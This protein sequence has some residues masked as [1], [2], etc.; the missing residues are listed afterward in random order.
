MTKKWARAALSHPAFTGLSRQHLSGLIEELA[1]PWCA[2][3]EAALHERRGHERLRAAGV[4]PTHELV[5]TDRVV[6]TL[7]HLRTNLPHAALAELYGIGRSTISEAISEIRPLLARRGFDLVF[8]GGS[9][10]GQ[11]V[12]I[13]LTPTASSAGSTGLWQC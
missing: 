4:G 3:H 12:R 9:S 6:L 2:L 8:S 1:E 7:V 5:F 11:A 10:S 13:S